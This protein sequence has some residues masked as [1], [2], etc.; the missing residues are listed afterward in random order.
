MKQLIF[1]YIRP[2]LFLSIVFLQ[3]SCDGSDVTEQTPE[4]EVAQLYRIDSL[5]TGD[6]TFFIYKKTTENLVVGYNPVFIQLKNNITGKYVEDAEL[7]WK[8]LMHMTTT[9]HACPYSAI[10]K[11]PDTKTLY[12]GYFIFIM[13]SDDTEFW[14]IS[15]NYINGTDTLAK[16]ANRPVVVNSSG[17]IHYKSFI[18][19]DDE[20]YF[21]ALVDPIKPKV[22][23]NDLTAHLYKKVDRFTFIPVENYNIEIDPRMPDMDN[24]S[25]PNNVNLV[26][27]STDKIYKGKVNLTM[28]GYWKINL[29]VR[30]ANNVI[31][32]GEEI[33]SV[34]A[35][36]SIFFEL[37]F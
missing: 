8:P 28:T 34:K 9:S 33:S 5:N 6:Y 11:V 2:L 27:S 13:A 20:F 17:K 16:A 35:S 29:V 19:T 25:S 23:T 12:Q 14:E 24:H 15:Y 4:S 7:S 26:H 3:M 10:S 37:E 36:S 32:K 31:I 22:G 18:G 30:D 1:K 21:L